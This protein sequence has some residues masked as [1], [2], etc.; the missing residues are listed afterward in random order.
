MMPDG[1]VEDAR[2][3]INYPLMPAEEEQN[4]KM[5]MKQ[6]KFP[7]GGEMQPVWIRFLDFGTLFPSD[8]NLQ[9]LLG[10]ATYHRLATSL[11]QF[12]DAVGG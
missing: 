3:P 10:K 7:Y 12:R 1:V 5:M 4:L 6:L 11:L 9:K 2:M 8:K